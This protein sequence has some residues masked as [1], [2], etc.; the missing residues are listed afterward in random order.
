VSSRAFKLTL[1]FAGSANSNNAVNISLV[2]PGESG[3]K[4]LHT[5]NPKMTY[6]IFGDEETIF[7]YQG[8][9]VNLRYNACDMRPGVQIVYTKRFKTIGETS[10]TDLRSVLEPYL[11]KSEHEAMLCSA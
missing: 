4:T 7:G 11:P 2:T 1:D 6:S 10:P 8:L 3:I 9:K 5:F